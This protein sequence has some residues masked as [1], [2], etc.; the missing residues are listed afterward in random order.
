M[1]K[2]R[3]E[4]IKKAIKL[5]AQDVPDDQD[6]PRIENC[7]RFQDLQPGPSHNNNNALREQFLNKTLTSQNVIGALSGRVDTRHI[8][9]ENNQIAGVYNRAED[10][11]ARLRGNVNNSTFYAHVPQNLKEPPMASSRHESPLVQNNNNA[12]FNFQASTENKN[13][14]MMNSNP[15]RDV[16]YKVQSTGSI[17][18]ANLEMIKKSMTE[19][20]KRKIS[21]PLACPPS[22]PYK[23]DTNIKESTSDSTYNR[24]VHKEMIDKCVGTTVNTGTLQFE[25]TSN[26]L[27]NLNEEKKVLLLEFMKVIICNFLTILNG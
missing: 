17:I 16:P 22:I 24:G 1:I 7:R 14:V 5:E 19:K 8:K 10:V 15:Y 25:I 6:V 12:M 4:L 26:E 27:Q 9:H 20:K 11:N 23:I 21:P 3:L 2:N 13:D 18:G